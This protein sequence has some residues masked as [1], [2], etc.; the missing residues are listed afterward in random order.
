MPRS[1]RSDTAPAEGVLRR[2]RWAVEAAAVD[3]CLATIGRLSPRRRLSVGD[4]L[5]TLFWAVDARHRRNAQRN[6]ALAFGG[7]LSPRDVRRLTLASMRH[8]TRV[9]V[10]A[11]AFRDFQADAVRVE[12]IEH[13]RTALDRGRGLLGFSAHFG[14]WEL[15]RFAAGY[16]GIPSFAIARPLENP[17]LEKR[18]ANVRALGGN[19]IIAKHGAVSSALKLLREGRFVAM[20]ID[21]RPE[22]SGVP[23]SFFGRR[24]FATDAL[25]VLALR[26]GAPVVPGFA[27]LEPDGSWRVVIEPEVPIVASGDLRA[28]VQRVMTDCTAILEVWVRRYPEQWLWTHAKL[29]P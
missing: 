1:R 6:I 24:A 29:K 19:G 25:A 27:V 11:T 15:L 4:A 3:V 20:M 22:H 9:I 18:L 16:H 26:T 21:Q 2:A 13:L 8:Y 28:D 7:Q 14:H 23:V 12:G 10:E 17:R 5:G